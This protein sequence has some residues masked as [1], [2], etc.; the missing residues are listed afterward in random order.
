MAA[1]SSRGPNGAAGDVVKPDLIA[2]G[3][4]VLAGNTPASQVGAPGPL[5]QAISGTSMST[6]HVAG[7]AARLRDAHP[8]WSPATIRSALMT[9]GRQNGTKEDGTTNADPFDVGG[10]HI[11]PTP[12]ADPGLVYG[13]G[14][15]DYLRFLCGTRALIPR[16][17]RAPRPAASTRATSTCRRSA[18]TGSPGSRR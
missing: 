1:F 15:I 4:V 13:A 7:V 18:S 9:G 14:F 10:G 2:P 8:D 6:P 3:V 12:A 11:V 5:S 17:R 16:A